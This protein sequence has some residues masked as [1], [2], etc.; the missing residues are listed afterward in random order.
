VGPGSSTAL[1]PKFAS[2]VSDFT[3]PYY[4]RFLHMTH[5]Y[6]FLASHPEGE[7]IYFEVRLRNSEGRPVK[8][9]RFPD[10][11]ANHWVRHRQSLLAKGLGFDIPVEAPRGEAIPAPGKTMP[12]VTVWEGTPGDPVLR[13]RQVKENLLPKDRPSFQPSPWSK[14]LAQSYARHL[15]REHGAA[16]A[17]VIRHSRNPV[18][19]SMLLKPDQAFPGI[20]ED[21][22]CSFGEYR[23]E[24]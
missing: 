4:L 14:L 23:L 8:T 22:I 7:T 1:A 15:C 12:T 3:T 6:H 2:D 10:P 9:L 16:S 11:D 19:P 17:E 24:D 21:L 5:N 13:L 20:F 18:Q